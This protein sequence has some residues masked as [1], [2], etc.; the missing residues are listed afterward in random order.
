M[1]PVCSSPKRSVL[2][3][4]AAN[5]SPH[6]NLSYRSIPSICATEHFL[7]AAAGWATFRAETSLR[8]AESVGRIGLQ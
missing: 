4:N 6:Q 5:L 8:K 2:P 3:K 7:L 1:K